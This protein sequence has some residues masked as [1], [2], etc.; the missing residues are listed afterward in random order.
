MTFAPDPLL[1]P[2]PS[3]GAA[4]QEN[5]VLELH[6]LHPFLVPV[7]TFIFFMPAA[8]LFPEQLEAEEDTTAPSTFLPFSPP[9]PIQFNQSPAVVLKGKPL[10]MSMTLLG[11][12][13]GI[14]SLPRAT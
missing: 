1:C 8:L 6:F 10:P 14:G 5:P 11:N 13:M 3:L 7:F 12:L 9:D 2:I 4:I